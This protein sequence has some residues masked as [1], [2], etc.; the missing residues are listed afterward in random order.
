MPSLRPWAGF[1]IIVLAT[2][3][4]GPSLVSAAWANLGMLPLRDGFLAAETDRS[5]PLYDVLG[6]N[7]YGSRAVARLRHAVAWDQAAVAP[8]WAMGRAWLGMGNGE[9]AAESMQPLLGHVAHNPLLYHDALRAFSQSAR[10]DAVVALYDSAKL[11]EPTQAMSDSVAL[12]YLQE[13]RTQKHDLDEMV[14]LRPGDLYV[15]YYLWRA[16]VKDGRWQAAEAY[17]EALTHFPAEALTPTDD[18]LLDYAVQ[19]IPLLLEDG[20]W[21]RRDA[22]NVAAYL[23]WKHSEAVS[24]RVLIQKLAISYPLQWEWPFYLGEAY[25]RGGD[26]VE[27]EQAY[28]RALMI[29][30]SHAPIY[31]RLGLVSQALGRH[32]SG[33]G[34]R[35]P[36]QQAAAYYRHYYTLASDDL[37]GVRLLI[38]VCTE[39]QELELDSQ[40]CLDA[41][42]IKEE[43]E[44]RAD[45]R[46]VVAEVLGV[47]VAHVRLGENL[48]NNGTFER[49]IGPQP[50]NWRLG[51]YLGRSREMGLYFADEDTFAAV[52]STAR[53]IGFWGGN[54]PDGTTTHAEYVAD[55][56]LMTNGTYVVSV[57]Y[58]S[59]D[60]DGVDL[61]YLGEYARADGVVLVHAGLPSTNGRWITKHVVFGGPAEATTIWTLIRNWGEGQIWVDEAMI[62]QI[63]PE[64]SSP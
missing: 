15:N 33:T 42:A 61:L 55:P 1:A 54:L 58:A 36:L 12:A 29:D 10:P 56:V 22:G 5:Y 52:G 60:S 20:F 19:V 2:L 41:Q 43:A 59:Q 37:V 13:G 7:R 64:K 46:L 16:T 26:L 32:A 45:G 47:P 11:P 18:R 48:L 24:V 23:V 38:E 3:L 50:E 44:A 49:W 40:H 63:L 34:A 31:L 53:I 35:Q 9:A 27:A 4:C 6:Y 14:R 8:R 39:L 30:P 25:H 17:S 62:R 28:H 57:R 21:D 51:T